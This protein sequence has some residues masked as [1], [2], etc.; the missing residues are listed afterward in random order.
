MTKMFFPQTGI[1]SRTEV[2]AQIEKV[3]PGSRLLS[4]MKSDYEPGQH[5]NTEGLLDKKGR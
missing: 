3:Y 4:Y 1:P 2:A 5:L